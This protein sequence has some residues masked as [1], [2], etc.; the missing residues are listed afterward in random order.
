MTD[1]GVDPSGAQSADAL[2][3]RLL[4]ARLGLT[5]EQVAAVRQ[6]DY[7]ALLSP[8]RRHDPLLAAAVASTLAAGRAAPSAGAPAEAAA[9]RAEADELERLRHLLAAARQRIHDL[10]QDLAAADAMVQ[11]IAQVFGACPACWGQNR[12][13]VRCHGKGLPGSGPVAEEE[14]LAWVRPALRSLG[15]RITNIDR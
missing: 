2:M 14:L 5:E 10:K 11:Y 4:A 13:C 1:P 3:T 6:G 15:L 7:S 9:E 8:E 12:L